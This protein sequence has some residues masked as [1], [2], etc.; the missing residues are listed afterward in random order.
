MKKFLNHI[1]FLGIGGISQ[2]AIALIL[3]SQ[4]H[5]VSGSDRVGS[6]VTKRLQKEGIDVCIGGVSSLIKDADMLV[7][8]AAI[9]DDDRELLLA[10]KLCKKIISR[11]Q[12]LGMLAGCYKNVISIAGSHG[13]TTTTAMISKIFCEAGLDPTV[14]I[15]GEVDFLDGN[16]RVGGDKFFITEACEYVDSFLSLKSDVSVILNVQ[17]DHLDYFKTFENIKK[18]F[19]KFAGHTKKTGLVVYNADDE[20]AKMNGR[21][22]SI[23]YSVRE[24]GVIC[25]KNV[26]EYLPGKYEFDCFLLGKKLFK[27]RLGVFGKHNIQN[28]LASISVALFYGV[29]AKYIKKALS[30]FSGVKRRFQHYPSFCGAEVYHDYAHHPTEIIATIDL[31][32]SIT[33]GD[34][35]VVFQPHTFSRTKLLL[36]EFSTCFKGAKEVLVYKTYPARENKEAGVDQDGLAQAISQTGQMAKSF[37][38]YEEMKKYL[39]ERLK[40]CDT[41]LILGAGDIE[42]VVPL[43]CERN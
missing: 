6:E 27:I 30:D 7:V 2:S 24:N 37:L 19:K 26:K 8:S 22:K 15:G 14:H 11:S 16:V 1:H 42:R 32:K 39:E 43:V 23:G 38:N 36:N 40:P 17:K 31:A 12:A 9:A 34:I 3:K 21:Q 28:A 4:G 25:A 18:S 10:K 29:K 35:Y 33:K 41:L 5:V 13:K 20:N